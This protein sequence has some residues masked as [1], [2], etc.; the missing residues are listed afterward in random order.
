MLNLVH[1][2]FMTKQERQRVRQ[3]LKERDLRIYQFAKV[4]QVR[5]EYMSQVLTGKKKPS[6]GLIKLMSYVL[7]DPD[8]LTKGTT[9]AKAS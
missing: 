6:P 1:H 9:R 5:P 8:V 4:C 3:R 7:A 2:C